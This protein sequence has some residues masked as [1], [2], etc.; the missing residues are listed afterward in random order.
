MIRRSRISV[1]PNVSVAGRTGP[2]ATPQDAPPLTQEASEAQAEVNEKNIATAVTDKCT[3]APLGTTT[4]PGDTNDQ[5]GEGTV[6][7]AAVQR[8]KR[9]SV[10]PRVAPGRTGTSVRTPKSPAKAVS[11]SPVQAPG[12][13]LDSPTTSSQNEMTVPQGLRSPSRRRPSGESRQPKMQP[14]ATLPSPASP[15]PTAV[16]PAEDPLEQA[17]LP[18]DGGKKL[19]RLPSNEA[20]EVPPRPPDKVPPSLPE[21]AAVVIS[22]RAK[23]LVS[24]SPK[25][26]PSLSPPKFSLSRLLNDPTDLQRLAKARKLR[27]L[28]RQEMYK[29]KKLKKSKASPKE[30][31]PDP[32]KMT[33]RDLIYY[34]P[35]SN[36]MTSYLED[37][38]NENETVVPPSPAREE[39]PERAQEPEIQ[40]NIPSQAMEED[41]EE[42][43]EEKDDP[44]MVPRVKVAEDG[45]LIIDEESLTVEVKRAKGPN[46]A[47]ERDPIFERGSTTTYSSFRKGN[48]TK[49]WSNEETDMFF[50]AI[51]MVGTDFS[52]ICQLF[53]HR[54][55][56]EIKNKFKKEER[57]NAWRI[58]KAFRERRKLDLEFFSKLLEKIL[59]KGKNKKPKSPTEKKSIK[60]SNKKSKGKKKAE[61]KLSDVEEE[62][63]EQE[64]GVPD[65]EE[66]EGEKENE[67]I[68]NEGGTPA[69]T[70]KRKC[71]RKNREESSTQEPNDKNM[72]MGE[73]NNEQGEAC[74]PEDAEAALPE[75]H[76]HLDM[77]EKTESVKAAKGTVI[78]P[79]QLSRGRAPKPLLP[80][81]RKW[82]RK[83]PT[84]STKPKEGAPDAG[85]ENLADVA[86]KAQA[87]KDASISK[88]AKDANKDA[89]PSTP[90]KDVNTDASPSTPSKDVNKDAPPSRPAKKR[91]LANDKTSS[92]G[93]EDSTVTPAKPT[94]YGRMPKPIQHLNYPAKEDAHSS[95]SE[96]TSSS[97]T[98]VGSTSATAKPKPKCPAK[99][100]RPSK[101]H[102]AQESKKPKL[103]TL[104]ASQSE[105]SDDED[106]K[107]RAAEEMEEH[108]P[109][110]SSK[111]SNAPVFVPVS[112]RSPQPVVPEV[113][114]TMEELDILVNMPDVL[115]LSQDALCPDASFEQAQDETGTVEP[116]EHQLDL[117]V[118]VIDLLSSDHMEVSE[119]E[120][121]NEAAQTLLTIGNLAHRSQSV[122]SHTSTQDHTTGATSVSGNDT[123][124][125]DL[126]EEIVSKPVAQIQNSST[127]PMTVTSGHTSTDVSQT[128][129]TVKP[130]NSTIDN[131]PIS[132]IDD[133]PIIET[134]DQT[135]SK[136]K[137]VADTEP[138]PQ[139]ESISKQNSPQTR[140]GRLS[141]VKPKPNLGR[142]TGSKAQPMT[143]QVST[144]EESNTVAPELSRVTQSS[145]A[146][147]S[148]SKMDCDPASLTGDILAEEPSASQEKAADT[149][150]AL[151]VESVSVTSDKNASQSRSHCFSKTKLKP[152]LGQASGNARSQ[153][154]STDE[155][156]TK[157]VETTESSSTNPST[158]YSAVRESQVGRGSITIESVPVQE[159]SDHSAAIVTATEELS[160]SQ[161]EESEVG[162]TCQTRKS[163][164]YK[165]KPNLRQTSRTV[166]AK[167][168]PREDT[169]THLE[170]MEN[171]S[172]PTSNPISTKNTVAL[173]EPQPTCSTTPHAEPPPS[174][175]PASVVMMSPELGSTLTPTE[176]ISTSQE[177]KTEGRAYQVDSNSEGSEW[178]V[179]QKRRRFPKVKPKPN[180]GSS[181][182]PIQSKLQSTKDTNKL[183][184]QDH[185]E[186]SSNVS[187]EQQPMK[188]NS[189]HTELATTDKAS[190]HLA[191]P[192]CSLNTDL[193]SSTN[194]GATES[195]RSFENATP[196]GRSSTGTAPETQNSDKSTI[197]GEPTGDTTSS[198]DKA[199]AGSAPQRGRNLRRSTRTTESNFQPKENATT[200]SEPQSSEDGS[201][202]SKLKSVLTTNV[203]SKLE[204]KENTQ[205]PCSESSDLIYID[206]SEVKG[207]DAFQKHRSEN[208][209]TNQT[210]KD[211]F[212]AAQ[213][214]DDSQSEPPDSDISSKKAPQTRRAR[215]PKPNL[216]CSS[217]PPD[218]QPVQ[219]TT[220][221]KS[222][223]GTCS[224]ALEDT[225]S[226][227]LD[228]KLSS[229]IQ[230]PVEGATIQY[231]NHDKP[232][233]DAV[234]TPG[235]VIQIPVNSS[236]NAATS[237]TGG[238][239]SYPGVTTH[240][241]V[242]TEQVPTDPEE[243]FFILSLTEIPVFPSADEVGSISEPLHYLP[244]TDAPIQLQSSALA[245]P[246]R[247]LAV[248]EDGALCNAPVPMP[249]EESGN[250]GFA[251]VKDVEPNPT[252]C[253]SS[254]MKKPVDPHEDSAIQ[255]S[256]LPEPAENSEIDVPFKKQRL[257]DTGRRAKLQVKPN[258]IRKKQASRTLAAEKA[259][260]I[261]VQ[262]NATQESELP[263]PPAQP[264]TVGATATTGDEVLT[265]PQ[266][267]TGGQ[268]DIEKDTSTGGLDSEKSSSEPQPQTSSEPHQITQPQMTRTLNRPGRKPKGFLSFLSSE[269]TSTAPSGDPQN[270]TTISQLPKVKTSCKGRKQAAPAPITSRAASLDVAPTPST[271]L[272]PEAT[273]SAST[274][275]ITPVDITQTA[276]N[277]PVCPDPEPCTSLCVAQVPATQQSDDVESSL[278]DEE[279]TSV[280]QYFLSDIFTEVDEG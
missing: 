32:A 105:Y 99:K 147:E 155:E 117:L 58:D 73:K 16:T 181:T 239:Q 45:S 112:L 230:E 263:C 81:G 236:Q 132:Q 34:L 83:H 15:G 64:N 178:N 50:L 139:I 69:S 246:G 187:S 194:S 135:Y 74:I 160:A 128:V 269:K 266:K 224:E 258:T 89:S 153:S 162:S 261:P 168:Q 12:S 255:P 104:R 264:E 5:S 71:K 40:P 220:Q 268:L 123:C 174:T 79:A 251:S 172:S 144:V 141:K 170:P 1:R 115:G 221:P 20:K 277:S 27:E 217:P 209:E 11:E 238:T 109:S 46:P 94:R 169:V 213:C 6:S 41:E 185:M 57:E 143:S 60:K 29:E 240:P 265:E 175:S 205:Q 183:S 228:L 212:Q 101:T 106:E 193:L 152:N 8:R 85:E 219:N 248:G 131:D 118:D 125:T 80:L 77:S 145:V 59:E 158:S 22:E 237:S 113:E 214:T 116:C 156:L 167:A 149:G 192:H 108:H 76:T 256:K 3:V 191:S 215:L 124:S 137:T 208:S 26:G 67:D 37:S 247:S 164:I 87:D 241:E 54:A 189:T 62:D 274:T 206:D 9:F 10:K 180:V 202:Q 231:S 18:A 122:K 262:T 218:L 61:R 216:G 244:V 235:C 211:N 36:P 154:Q 179:P 138:A 102:A 43:E 2:L 134:S 19:D 257:T 110:S 84:L 201:T 133:R 188:D 270:A 7:S 33:M 223:S 96:T 203:H 159:G 111:D 252:V 130:E 98:P 90:S 17:Q 75:D 275:R 233:N 226:H 78:K 56:S 38:V 279:P 182:R 127:P 272:F 119:K 140:R 229:D 146:E 82:G 47:E 210:T 260:L 163:R 52:M 242:L 273:H 21:K 249:M 49:P 171:T 142:A 184:E 35:M 68:S 91:K 63:E 253:T 199:E 280:S 200:I 271:A 126:K 95:A 136:Q 51:S 92:E 44:L 150:L 24:K 166:Q 66:V 42:A 72:K 121:Y 250:R 196:E 222:D 31:T 204:P 259:E 55:R 157:L 278:V 48:Y 254:I 103:V 234:F 129:E 14:K 198:Q 65:L 53:P 267:G 148:I 70:P 225:A 23:T 232:P 243:P 120:S 161:E 86:S 176:E 114:E 197:E 97:A 186:S 88:P 276:D 4:A 245:T 177:T 13:D 165:A 227:R 28:L 93:E 30:Y 25:S 39:S 195:E 107:Q 151:Q 173:L 190:K 100:T 207:Q